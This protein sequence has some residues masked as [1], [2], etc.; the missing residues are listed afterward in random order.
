[1]YVWLCESSLPFSSSSAALP[2]PPPTIVTS[3]PSVYLCPRARCF[4]LSCLSSA[5]FSNDVNH[6]SH[7]VNELHLLSDAF[8]KSAGVFLPRTP[9]CSLCMETASH[10]SFRPL[11]KNCG[12][13]SSTPRC[14]IIPAQLRARAMVLN[15]MKFTR[16]IVFAIKICIASCLRQPYPYFGYQHSLI[17]RRGFAESKH[18]QSCLRVLFSHAL[19]F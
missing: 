7:T 14:S 19:A 15:V 5:L 11:S 3:F 16:P 9:E 6:I 12:T 1:M 8:H 2:F 4:L 10:F 13:L 17:N 18:A